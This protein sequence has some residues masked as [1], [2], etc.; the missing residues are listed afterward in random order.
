MSD[1][2]WRPEILTLWEWEID[3]VAMKI[4]YSGSG[5]LFWFGIFMLVLIYMSEGCHPRFPLPIAAVIY[6]GNGYRASSLKMCT[7]SFY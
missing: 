4:N 1:E 6:P 5:F 3:L 7:F 2:V